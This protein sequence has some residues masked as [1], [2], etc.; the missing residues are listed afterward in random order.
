[1][2]R[3][4]I[5]L[6]VYNGENYLASAIDT[7]LAQTYGD[8]DFLI[9][10]N[11]SSDGTE[12]ICQGYAKRDSRIRY[13]RQHKNV[14]AA[15]N[16]NLL[17]AMTDTP[18]F[19][20]AAHDDVLAPAFLAACIDV[21]DRDPAVVLASPATTLI[22]EAGVPLPY[23]AELGGL[24]DRSGLCWPI[25][26]ENNPGLMAENPAVRFEAVMLKMFMCVEIF[27][28]MRRPMILRTSLHGPFV[29]SDKVMLAELALLGRF[30]LGQETLFFRRCHSKQFSA[31]GSGAYRAQ[32]FSGRRDSMVAQQVK[33]LLAYCRAATT[34]ELTL[35]QRYTCFRALARRAYQARWQPKR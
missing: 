11:A 15:A 19:K 12:E 9:S 10:D 3:V 33:L 5:G 14:G 18:Y 20:W 23:S 13:V 1:M 29:G 26:P 21:L 8:F 28:L 25:M 6:P 27:G 34:A 24:V 16:Y 2:K 32:W 22:D 7:I 35:S 17:F 30:W 4:T 31:S